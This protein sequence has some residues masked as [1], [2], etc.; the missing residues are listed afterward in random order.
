MLQIWEKFITKYIIHDCQVAFFDYLEE[1][2]RS[3][4]EGKK[5]K[6]L[7]H[8]D[9][10]AKVSEKIGEDP[11]LVSRF[12]REVDET[13]NKAINE[14]SYFLKNSEV[15][16]TMQVPEHNKD[17]FIKVSKKGKSSIYLKLMVDAEDVKID[18]NVELLWTLQKMM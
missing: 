18:I 9:F 6:F 3:K 13:L 7:G 1:S 15:L 4:I 10:I 5:E 17:L 12:A 11:E 16:K 14:I 8:K 2:I